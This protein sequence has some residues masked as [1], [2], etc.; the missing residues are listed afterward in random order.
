MDSLD[1]HNHD[2]DTRKIANLKHV[3]IEIVTLVTNQNELEWRKSVTASTAALKTPHLLEGNHRSYTHTKLKELYE[4]LGLGLPIRYQTPSKQQPPATHEQTHPEW[5]VEATKAKGDTFA[6]SAN[7]FTDRII[8]QDLKFVVVWVSLGDDRLPAIESEY[9]SACRTFLFTHMKKSLKA[10]AHMTK[11]VVHG[12]CRALFNA[13]VLQQH[14]EPR[15]LLVSCFNQLVE[16]KKT[17]STPFQSWNSGLNDIFNTLDTVDFSLQPHVRLGF[18]MALLGHDKRYATILEKAQEKEWTNEECYIH[19]DRAAAKINDQYKSTRI[20]NPTHTANAVDTAATPKGGAGEKGKG[21]WGGKY[22]KGEKG[23]KGRKGEQPPPADPGSAKAANW[24]ANADRSKWPC[25]N[26]KYGYACALTPCPF[27]HAD[28]A[29]VAEIPAPAPAATVTFENKQLSKTERADAKD[30]GIC[31]QW[32]QM[33]QCTNG[34]TCWFKHS[35]DMITAGWPAGTQVTIDPALTN[36]IAI[37]TTTISSKTVKQPN[38]TTP[39]FYTVKLPVEHLHKLHEQF[40][41]MAN[42]GISE[43][44]LT[45][46]A[47]MPPATVAAAALPAT[48]AAAVPTTTQPAVDLTVHPVISP[49]PVLANCNSVTHGHSLNACIDNACTFNIINTDKYF[50]PGTIRESAMHA[51]FNQPGAG[52]ACSVSGLVQLRQEDGGIH[53]DRY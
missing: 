4:Q 9:D 41:A 23:G 12:D 49:T 16:H 40:T 17:M 6:Q 37:T 48:V 1:T 45:I 47:R 46:C 43:K 36:G 28:T 32:K 24:A 13:V 31:F 50:I 44:A 29:K 3:K 53:M 52:A 2:L 42:A 8:E 25:R 18:T 19:F 34:D 10:Y 39:R 7:S 30:K 27:K 51:S 15:Q 5:W 35:C 22:G 33:E 14:P 11:D 20:P 38:G 21:K 26:Q